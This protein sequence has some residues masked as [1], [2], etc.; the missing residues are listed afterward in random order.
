MKCNWTKR[1]VLEYKK[2]IKYIYEQYGEI[3]ALKFITAVE[4][5][6]ANLAKYPEIGSPEQ[7]LQDRT[8][9]LYRSHTVG[10]H[11]KLVYTINKEGIVTIVD[12]WDMRRNPNR[13]AN[14]IKSE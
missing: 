10:T 11:N 14:R 2:V 8:K 9:Y 5:L 12:M 3:S 6:D 7:L 13:L 1:A 4:H